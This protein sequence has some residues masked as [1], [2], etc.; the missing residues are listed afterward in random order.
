MG[1][2]TNSGDEILAAELLTDPSGPVICAV[3][4][5]VDMSNA[6]ELSVY[7][8]SAFKAGPDVVVDL[9]GVTFLASAGVRVLLKAYT[10]RRG[11]R[12]AIVTNAAIEAVLRI[13]G[14]TA[15]VP[16]RP[17]RSLAV[18]E[19]VRSASAASGDGSPPVG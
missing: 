18:R 7:L 15:V 1:A 6:D 19:L 17:T 8:D 4:G 11:R 16:C 9:S 3:R 12:I 10:D 5:E 14:L 2:A 13:C